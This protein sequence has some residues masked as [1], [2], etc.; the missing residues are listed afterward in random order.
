MEGLPPVVLA[1]QEVGADVPM[2]SG[3][4][5]V[6]QEEVCLVSGRGLLPAG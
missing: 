6:D 3:T 2:A 4:L 5:T 1:M